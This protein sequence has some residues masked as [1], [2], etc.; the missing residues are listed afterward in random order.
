MRRCLRRIKSFEEGLRTVF[1]IFP[2]LQR[3][4]D[5]IGVSEISVLCFV[6]EYN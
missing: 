3:A 6:R 4:L 5:V 2:Q 1:D